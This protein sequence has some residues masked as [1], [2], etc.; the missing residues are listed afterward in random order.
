MQRMRFVTRPRCRLYEHTTFAPPLNLR[1][2]L[3]SLFS[4]FVGRLMRCYVRP[5]PPLRVREL[6]AVRL[7]EGLQLRNGRRA[8]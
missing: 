5:K 1:V 2:D 4:G 8:R 3:V 6:H 7:G